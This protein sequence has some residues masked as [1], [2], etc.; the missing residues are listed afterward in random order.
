MKIMNLRLLLAFVIVCSPELCFSEDAVAFRQR[1]LEE[2]LLTIPDK[3]LAKQ[4]VEIRFSREYKVEPFRHVYVGAG[5]KFV[6][7]AAFALTNDL[8]F[9]LELSGITPAQ[10]NESRNGSTYLSTKNNTSIGAYLDWY[11]TYSSFRLVGGLN[12]NSLNRTMYG[13]GNTISVN[14]KQ[15]NLSG[16]TFNVQYKFPR[17]TPY[18]GIGF[19]HR[20]LTKDGW[21]FFGDLGMMLGKYDAVATTSVIGTQGI[22]ASDV[23]AAMNNLRKSLYK[24][25]FIPTATVGLT[26]RFN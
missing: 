1:I 21:D 13:L 3:E 7:G 14:G 18:V 15:V 16:E 5:T 24:W 4:I 6:A 22:Q 26:Y 11:P 9:R 19:G 23:D 2:T 25:N 10:G 17:V 8:S 12:I 20:N